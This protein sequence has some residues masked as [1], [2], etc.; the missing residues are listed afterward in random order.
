M[1]RKT[2]ECRQLYLDILRLLIRAGIYPDPTDE[3]LADVIMASG[4]RAGDG[5]KNGDTW[6]I[7]RMRQLLGEYDGR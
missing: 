2:N 5:R 7:L 6:P 3:E 1:A 4:T